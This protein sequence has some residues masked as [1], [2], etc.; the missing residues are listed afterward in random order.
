[1][2]NWNRVFS[3]ISVIIIC[4]AFGVICIHLVKT[5]TISQ[6][7]YKNAIK[8]AGKISNHYALISLT[9]ALDYSNIKILIVITGI[10]LVFAGATSLLLHENNLAPNPQGTLQNDLQQNQGL[11]TPGISFVIIG[12][13][14]INICLLNS[15]KIELIKSSKENYT[16]ASSNDELSTLQSKDSTKKTYQKKE[17][18]NSK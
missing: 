4:I 7:I 15:P 8:E 6:D 9:K 17:S 10:I 5:I 18:I 14:T 2:R 12:I 3:R 1:M 16:F 13:I 11:T